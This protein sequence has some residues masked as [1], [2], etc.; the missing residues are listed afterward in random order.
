MYFR[1]TCSLTLKELCRLRVLKC[2][3]LRRILET[4][5]EVTGKRTKQHNVQLLELYSWP[6]IFWVIKS[7]E[8]RMDRACGSMGEKRNTFKV[9]VRKP[10]G[11]KSL[12]L[13]RRRGKNN[14]K[15][16]LK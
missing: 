7:K 5:E 1:G 2:K 16:C 4:E 8:C 6:D 10:E 15:I 11:N 9:L 14:I 3:V 12:P 13:P